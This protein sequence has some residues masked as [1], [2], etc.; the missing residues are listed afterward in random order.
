MRI[1]ALERDKT[2]DGSVFRVLTDSAR[3]RVPI[4]TIKCAPGDEQA[5]REVVTEIQR[6]LPP[7][8]QTKALRIMVAALDTSVEVSKDVPEVS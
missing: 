4:A 8:V 1:I 7:S 6:I 5:V 2:K 3:P